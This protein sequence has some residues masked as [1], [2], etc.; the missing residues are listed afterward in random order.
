MLMSRR[1][2]SYFSLITN[3]FSPRQATARV[4][5]A[6]PKT[7][8]RGTHAVNDQCILRG[9]CTGII[10]KFG[11]EQAVVSDAA[12]VEP[13][14]QWL[15]PLG[16]LEQDRNPWRWKRHFDASTPTVAA[17]CPAHLPGLCRSSPLATAAG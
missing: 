10:G 4:G 9:T 12:P 14:K 13:S 8:G 11:G 17:Q 5:R 15:K 7:I 1:T 3:G 2:W 16:M 6:C